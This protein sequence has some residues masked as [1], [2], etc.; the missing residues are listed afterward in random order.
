MA[1]HCMCDEKHC[2]GMECAK[3]SHSMIHE[4]EGF[5]VHSQL[6]INFRLRNILVKDLP[7]T[8]HVPYSVHRSQLVLASVVYFVAGLPSPSCYNLALILS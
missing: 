1:S 2:M 4:I 8:V 6:E 7:C 3:A 5:I